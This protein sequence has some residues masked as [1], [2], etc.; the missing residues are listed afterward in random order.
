M[1]SRRPGA[2]ATLHTAIGRSVMAAPHTLDVIV[3]VRVLAAEL[4]SMSQ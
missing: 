3:Q 4:P 2:L 1:T